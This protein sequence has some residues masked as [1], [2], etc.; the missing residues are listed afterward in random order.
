M[1]IGIGELIILTGNKQLARW[2]IESESHFLVSAMDREC[3][4]YHPPLIVGTE[5][6]IA[7][8]EKVEK[9]SLEAGR[10]I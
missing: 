2:K 8:N 1:T 10:F 7:N 4:S 9:W 5:V 3:S 6:Y